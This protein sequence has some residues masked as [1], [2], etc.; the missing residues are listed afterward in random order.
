[1]WTLTELFSLPN[2]LSDQRTNQPYAVALHF[3]PT[4]DTIIQPLNEYQPKRSIEKGGTMVNLSWSVAE[5]HK[6]NLISRYFINTELMT[7][8]FLK[9]CTP[10]GSPTDG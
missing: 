5:G 8:K 1:M 10:L 2:Q 7:G 6:T 9:I 4:G 3:F